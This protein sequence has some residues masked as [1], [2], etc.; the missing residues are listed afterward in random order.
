MM[1]RFALFISAILHPL[2]MP[3]LCVFIAY[4]FDWY[5]NGIISADQMQII[6]LIV[7]FSTIV[8]PGVNI[9]LLKWYGV[10]TSFSMRNRTERNAPYISTIFFFV[11]GYYMLRKGALPDS[12]FSIL[13][14]CIAT[15]VLITLIN[16][17][18]KISSH[19]AGIFG[20]LGAVIA[21]FRIHSFG[22]ITLLSA[23]LLAGGLV[24]TSRL[25]LNAHT[26]AE[27]YGG[28]ILGF[29]TVYF[30]V[31]LGFFI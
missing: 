15:L 18:W 25:M 7:A 6:Y 9:L 17:K 16:F 8:F 28:A 13:I 22:N 30:C 23:L 27:S 26:P 12:L 4:Q 11:L 24:I 19:S 1:R 10:V 14:G 31:Y 2:F 5:I 29:T 20:I 3:L 21:L